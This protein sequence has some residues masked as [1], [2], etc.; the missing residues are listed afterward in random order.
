MK[1]NRELA[2]LVSLFDDRDTAVIEAVNSKLISMGKDVIKELESPLCAKSFPL[3]K[4]EIEHKILFLNKEFA[5]NTLCQYRKLPDLDLQSGFALISQIIDDN[6]NKD[7]YLSL[8][9]DLR[10]T[11]AVELSDNYTQVE[12]VKIF[13]HLFFFRFGFDFNKEN[14]D[15]E[16]EA[17][18]YP[19]L[20]AKKGHIVVISIIYFILARS[21][22]LPIFPVESKGGFLP[23]CIDSKGVIICF[24][25]ILKSGEL[26]KN[27]SLRES[28]VM[29]D[30]KE[31]FAIYLEYL[32]ALYEFSSNREQLL[33]VEKLFKIVTDK[34]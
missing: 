31:L 19:V 14:T 30:D 27:D 33:I 15:R 32:K 23:A 34:S 9:Q 29:N 22:F 16:D 25:N 18:I 21:F 5:F 17:L 26:F 6:F 12:K 13:N 3:L 10:S 28:S 2:A 7:H 1:L 11:L 24:I 8:L 20:M 4:E